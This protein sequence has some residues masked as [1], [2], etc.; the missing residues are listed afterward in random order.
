MKA[1]ALRFACLALLA[2]LSNLAN[3][4]EYATN[5]DGTESVLSEGGI[6]S[7]VGLDWTL[8]RTNGDIA[9]G[10]HKATGYNDSYAHLTGFSADQSAEGTIFKSGTF[11]GNQEIE[12]HLRW[13]DSAHSARGYEILVEA[14]NRYAYIVRWNGPLGDFTI[15]TASG[16]VRLPRAPVTGDIIK[17][18]IVGS[19]ITVFFNGVQ[20]GSVSDSTWTTGNPGI[21]FYSDDAS[22]TQNSRFGFTAFTA[23]DDATRAPPKA[24][25]GLRVE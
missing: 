8:V 12:L 19:L 6:W 20:V 7:N 25:T 1:A 16:A 14:N 21:G 5:F 9:Y 3:A 13:A 24:P 22:G 17:A 10:T 15:L 4:K 23:R 18:Q 2:A 11:G